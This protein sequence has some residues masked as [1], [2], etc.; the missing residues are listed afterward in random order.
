MEEL[1]GCKSI[2]KWAGGKG[3]ISKPIHE[4]ITNFVDDEYGDECVFDVF[5]E[6][7]MGGGGLF[8]GT[9]GLRQQSSTTRDLLADNAQYMLSDTNWWL[10]MLHKNVSER[11]LEQWEAICRIADEISVT[12]SGYYELRDRYNAAIMSKVFETHDYMEIPAMLYV[13]NR[14]CYNGLYRVNKSGRFNVPYGGDGR[15]TH[16]EDTYF[17]GKRVFSALQERGALFAFNGY[18]FVEAFK[19]I[20][21]KSNALIY[22]DPPYITQTAANVGFSTY[23]KDGFN[24]DSLV[25]LLIEVY[26]FLIKSPYSVVV[27]S[28]SDNMEAILTDYLRYKGDAES[29]TKF[30]KMKIAMGGRTLRQVI[31]VVSNRSISCTT[32]R[33]GRTSESLYMFCRNNELL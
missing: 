12:S 27:M 11:P 17:R 21:T 29:M 20:S 18:D 26:N 5:C 22:L 6:P 3:S 4:H 7:F 8:Y 24:Y 23:A 19:D 30:A 33:R 9:C 28:N 32:S 16:N 14:L 25:D 1:I 15:T 2:L 13:V 31:P 10:M